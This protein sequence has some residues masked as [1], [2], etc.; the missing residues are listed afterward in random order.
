MAPVAL[1]DPR[2]LGE[3]VKDGGG[4]VRHDLVSPS[5][6]QM[7]PKI[8]KQLLE[9]GGGLAM[10]PKVEHRADILSKHDGCR[11]ELPGCQI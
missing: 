4:I 11:V 6:I 8:F 7:G 1:V 10:L 3:V 2:I 9:G 5:T